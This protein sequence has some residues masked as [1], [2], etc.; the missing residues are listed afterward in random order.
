LTRDALA[1]AIEALS[2]MA[3]TGI[4][5]RGAL[6]K[7]SRQL[8]IED[9]KDLRQAH[10]WIMETSR[11][12]NRLD[13]FTSQV[14]FKQELG[15]APHGIRSLLRVLSY[16]KWVAHQSTT[17]L[18]RIVNW[19]RQIIGWRELLPYEEAVARVVSSR[20][21]PSTSQLPEV[22]RLALETC[23]PAW[24]VQHLATVFGRTYA[25]KILRRDLR[26][27]SSYL[28]LNPLKL[29]GEGFSEQAYGAK[30]PG[31]EDVYVLNQSLR[32]DE[33]SGLASSGRIVIQ[34]LGSIVAGLVASP[35]PGQV[36]L[37]LCAAP[38]N[39]TS[40]LGAQMNND[41][42]IYSVELSKT[43]SAQW[44]KEMSRTGCTIANLIQA[45]A[46]KIP[47]QTAANVI[48]V[49]PPCSNSG[50]FA[51]NPANKWRITPARLGELTRLQAE[52]LQ[53]A[54]ERVSSGGTM[55]YC[56]CSILPEENEMVV[57]TFLRRNP[58]F[59]VAPQQPFVG[60][61]G[62]RGLTACQRFFPHIHDCNGAF[63]AN[64]RKC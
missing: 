43:R 38:G 60:S 46:R 17:D 52:I 58:E 33:R 34:D 39:K 9:I 4:G 62:L 7:S 19:G 8:H 1:V 40:H 51:R 31:L 12:R 30:F 55:V 5:E 21:S 2:W 22:E 23:H 27:V 25:L 28:R 64:I 44:K 10:K 20:S 35:R 15:E 53:A 36:V 11:F 57:E 14:A 61:P 48:L 54:S 24:Y 26:P 32:G 18:E 59:T 56:T 16:T 29:E 3:Y 49:D 47:L 63:V 6:L 45:D 50:V 13:W 37:D 41:G 42:Q